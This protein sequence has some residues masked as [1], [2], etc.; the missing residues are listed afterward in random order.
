M[1][2]FQARERLTAMLANLGATDRGAAGGDLDLRLGTGSRPGDGRHHSRVDRCPDA[3]RTLSDFSCAGLSVHLCRLARGAGR[4]QPCAIDECP[5]RSTALSSEAQWTRSPF[6]AR[7]R[8]AGDH[9][10]P[11]QSQALDRRVFAVDRCVDG[12]IGSAGPRPQRDLRML[13]TASAR[14]AA[15]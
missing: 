10:R 2:G 5:G 6:S 9:G 15:R 8:P 1:V 4:S 11:F 7:T 12:S 3:F 13:N 14:T